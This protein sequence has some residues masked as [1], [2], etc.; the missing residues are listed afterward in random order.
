MQELPIIVDCRGLDCPWPL[1]HTKQA[2][3][4]CKPGSLMQILATDPLAELDLKSLCAREGHDWISTEHAGEELR[5]H[6]RRA[7][8]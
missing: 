3:S 1:L 7:S 4:R 5:I 2:L 6:L 8:N